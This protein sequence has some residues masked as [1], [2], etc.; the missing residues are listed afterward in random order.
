MQD[1]YWEKYRHRPAWNQVKIKIFR[2][3]KEQHS[4][5]FNLLRP[6]TIHWMQKVTLRTGYLRWQDHDVLL[7][8]KILWDETICSTSFG[9]WLVE[10][11]QNL[12]TDPEF[13]ASAKGII[14]YYG[15]GIR[16]VVIGSLHLI[17]FG[18][19]IYIVL[20]ISAVLSPLVC[21]SS[22]LW[23][24]RYKLQKNSL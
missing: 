8:R 1:I 13:R 23:Q 4:Y 9:L 16:P 3:A 2:R 15:A 5:V 21:K 17:V 14:S 11:L 7:N 24:K 22:V 10:K 19:R 12:I 20:T 6:Y 18:T